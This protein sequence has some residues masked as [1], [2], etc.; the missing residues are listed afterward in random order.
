MSKGARPLPRSVLS[1]PSSST[2]PGTSDS[3]VKGLRSAPLRNRRPVPYYRERNTYHYFRLSLIRP[4]LD[5]EDI[6]GVNDLGDKDSFTLKSGRR[7]RI[8]A[9]TVPYTPSQSVGGYGEPSFT[10]KNTLCIDV[11]TPVRPTTTPDLCT[12]GTT[13]PSTFLE[14]THG[15]TVDRRRCQT[16][17]HREVRSLSTNL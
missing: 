12:S 14:E 3:I 1:Q 15:W 10:C 16:Y 7:G 11:T 6:V 13:L 9:P 4:R 2:D 5:T 8:V 17:K